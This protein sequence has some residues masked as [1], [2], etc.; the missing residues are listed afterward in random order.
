MSIID[1][2]KSK[3]LNR[4]FVA[5]SHFDTLLWLLSDI[6]SNKL[7]IKNISISTERFQSA[8]ITVIKKLGSNEEYF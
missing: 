7:M 8:I 2:G 4:A 6:L 5:I 3:I 1:C